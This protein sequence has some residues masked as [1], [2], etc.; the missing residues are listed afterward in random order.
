MDVFEKLF[1][2]HHRDDAFTEVERFIDFT[3]VDWAETELSGAALQRAAVLRPYQ[4]SV[5]EAR[6]AHRKGASGISGRN[7]ST[8]IKQNPHS[9]LVFQVQDCSA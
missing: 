6:C 1:H 9:Q 8:T 2:D 7:S 4:R 5:D 3:N